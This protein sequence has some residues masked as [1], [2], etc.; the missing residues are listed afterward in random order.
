MRNMEGRYEYIEKKDQEIKDWN[1]PELIN[2]MRSVTAGNFVSDEQKAEEIKNYK[3]KK[4]Q[5]EDLTVDGYINK[6]GGIES[7]VD[8]SIHTSKSSYMEHL[9]ANN[10]T[11]K[12]W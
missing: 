11:I 5:G 7:N 12:D 4:K 6:H 1:D 2:F 10:C 9:K 3:S 8:G